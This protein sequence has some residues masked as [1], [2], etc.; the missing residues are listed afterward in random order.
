MKNFLKTLQRRKFMKL[1]ASGTAGALTT[2]TVAIGADRSA[3]R[4][5]KP[6][7]VFITW[8]VECLNSFQVKVGTWKTP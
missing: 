3:S 4:L 7:M 5:L 2:A 1:F 8:T 6:G